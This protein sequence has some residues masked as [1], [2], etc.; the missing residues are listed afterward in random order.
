MIREITLNTKNDL[1]GKYFLSIEAPGDEN[2]EQPKK[3]NMKVVTVKPSNRRTDFTSNIEDEN[4]ENN[5]AQN[6]NLN[7]TDF[8][9]DGTG[10]DN[11][12]TTQQD[13][14]SSNTTDD[15]GDKKGPGLEYD[16][17]RK[18]ILFLNY[19]SL[20]NAVNNYITKLENN[21]G[22][23]TDSNKILKT[24]I[25]K[26]KEIKDL[27]YDYITMKFETSTYIQSLLFYQNIIVMV[28]LVF[29]MLIKMKD[30]MKNT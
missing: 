9:D 2:E 27:C 12:D 4:E 17:T 11:G 6:K 21:L 26:L 5:N 24:S 23:D 13:S 29:D 7:N 10:E 16:S 8:T 3:S 18:Y 19:Q 25:N 28:Q 14:D 30:H 1:Y 20:I 22:D 15:Q